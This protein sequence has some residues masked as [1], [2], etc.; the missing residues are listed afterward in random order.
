MKASIT[1]QSNDRDDAVT[2]VIDTTVH[3]LYR[4]CHT[5]EDVRIQCQE[6]LDSYSIFGG[7]YVR[8]IDIKEIKE[9]DIIST[10]S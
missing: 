1:T 8:I 3:A 2:M 7:L 5:L 4:G 6:I 10:T 9:D